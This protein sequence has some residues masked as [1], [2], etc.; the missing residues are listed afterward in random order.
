MTLRD[1]RTGG[2]GVTW[3]S[4]PRS[5]LP[6]LRHDP[7][8]EELDLR[9]FIR[10]LRVDEVV[11][12]AGLQPAGERRDQAF[13]FDV[14][15]DV[16]VLAEGDALAGE[17]GLQEQV[18]RS[19]RSISPCDRGAASCSNSLAQP[20]KTRGATLVWFNHSSTGQGRAVI[21]SIR[22]GAP[23]SRLRF[24]IGVCRRDKPIPP[25]K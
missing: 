10:T 2:V 25:R 19:S 18:A 20:P 16:G 9:S 7:V 21:T 3:L 4:E 11:A 6:R 22:G 14:V 15:G 5:P 17:G 13:L 24:A 8:L 1:A 12:E 23:G